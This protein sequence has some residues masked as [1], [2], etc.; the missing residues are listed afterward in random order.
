MI[1]HRG[2]V[3]LPFKRFGGEGARFAGAFERTVQM[4]RPANALAKDPVTMLLQDNQGIFDLRLRHSTQ[5][6]EQQ[7]VDRLGSQPLDLDNDNARRLSWWVEQ[8]IEEIVISRDQY[9]AFLLR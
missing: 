8:N 9:A 4:P 5:E 6:V 7:G 3:A 2:G 1:E